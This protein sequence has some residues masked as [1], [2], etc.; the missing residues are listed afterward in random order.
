MRPIF[1]PMPPS[2]RARFITSCSNPEQLPAT[3]L[4]R[5]VVLGRSNA[6]KSSLINALTGVKNLATV[7]ATPGRTRLINLFDVGGRYELVDLPGY[8]YAKGSHQERDQL[9][10]L[11]DGYLNTVPS[12]RLAIIIV[13]SRLGP[14]DADREMIDYVEMRGIPTAIVANKIDKLSKSEQSKS[15]HGIKSAHPQVSVIGHSAVTGSGKG[16]LVETIDRYTK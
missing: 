15:I 3:H 11:I 6:G 16:E 13:D 10:Y 9:T 1:P 4:P 14:T 8:G 5:V 12:P 7:S 2:P